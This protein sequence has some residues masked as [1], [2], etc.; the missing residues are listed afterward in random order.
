MTIE[1][2]PKVSSNTRSKHASEHDK[3]VIAEQAKFR[4]NV[5]AL[6][7]L[8]R[9]TMPMISFAVGRLGRFSSNSGE[10][11]W[12][13]MKHLI[14]FIKSFRHMGIRYSRPN[15][16]EPGYISS[17]VPKAILASYNSQKVPHF[18]CYTDSDFAGCP[19]SSR[20]TSGNVVVWMGAAIS[21]ASQL[22]ACVTLSTAEAEMVALSKL[23][24]EVIWLRRFIEEIFA[25][26]IEVPTKIY[27]DN[28]AT[29]KLIDN[30]V[31]H[32]RTKHI[33]LRQN[34]VREHKDSGELDPV[35]IAT[36]SNIADDFTKVLSQTVIDSHCPGIMGYVP[37]YS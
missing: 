24:Q 4:A 18:R 35:Y 15:P 9:C 12:K 1:D 21:W 3:K 32:A 8:C 26:D 31:H 13:E 28:Q 37:K 36:D 27:C 2:C 5:G 23:S 7:F 19:D 33:K 16:G 30:R 20:S 17:L 34:F 29:R 6:L 10:S 25:Y 22:Q 14:R 11:H